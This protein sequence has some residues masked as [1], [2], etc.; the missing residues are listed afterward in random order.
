MRDELL[1]PCPLPLSRAHAIELVARA[2]ELHTLRATFLT[3]VMIPIEERIG[4]WRFA[5]AAASLAGA[6]E[7][8]GTFGVDLRWT[9]EEDDW[10]KLL[11]SWLEVGALDIEQPLEEA[12]SYRNLPLRDL[13]HRVVLFAEGG[14]PYDD[15]GLCIVEV[16]TLAG[17]PFENKA[18]E[19]ERPSSWPSE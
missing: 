6:F 18:P 15:F 10:Q 1:Y 8:L 2:D 11:M 5:G 16:A 7:R 13:A 12:W 19:T 9:S 14:A 3:F 4:E 17:T